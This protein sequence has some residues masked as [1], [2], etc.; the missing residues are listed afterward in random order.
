MNKLIL[1]AAILPLL[2]TGASAV[3][4]TTASDPVLG[5]NLQNGNTI[6]QATVGTAGNTNNYPSAEG[7]E[8]TLDGSAGTKY[9]NFQKF[10]S[11]ILVNASNNTLVLTGFQLVAANDA[12]GRDP[13]EFSIYG[14]NQTQSLNFAD[15]TPIVLNQAILTTDPGRLQPSQF[16]SFDNPTNA[17]FDSYLVIF[18]TVRDPSSTD[19]PAGANSM[20]VAEIRLDGTAPIPEPSTL[21]LLGLT[22]IGIASLRRRRR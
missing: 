14:T 10:N 8:K 11:G 18:P 5:V 15:Y 20:Q 13:I 22:T 4:L 17:P 16:I 7:P 1:S 9:L 6:Q 3:L 19:N 2:S 12:P 21:G